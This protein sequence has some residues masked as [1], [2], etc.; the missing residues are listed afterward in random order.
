MCLIAWHWQPGA[1]EPLVLLSNRDEFFNRPA[2]TL[3][4][5]FDAPIWAGRDELAGGTWLGVGVSG[6]MA[7]ITN[8]RS[9]HSS[10]EL[11]K[12]RGH[13][14]RD[15]LLSHLSALDYAAYVAQN[16]SAYNPFN[17]WLFDGQSM[18]GVQ[19]RHSQSK[20]VTLTPGYGSVSN[21]DFNSPWPK[22][23]QLQAQLRTLIESGHAADDTLLDLLR[24][25]QTTQ[26]G[27]L[28]QTGVA[29][30]KELALSAMFVRLSD[31]GTRASTLVRY[32][33]E[34]V[35]M[36]ERS[37]DAQG[38]LNACVAEARVPRAPHAHQ[39]HRI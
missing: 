36:K 26:L 15:F 17:L 38:Q 27:D 25:T 5:W 1:P 39:V 19:G 35:R 23:L 18:M 32:G 20:V 9:M 8:Y 11:A 24:N 37:F 21:A 6:R 34:I 2:R 14:V 22:Q 30:E 4:R 33:L 31:Y 12:S 7:A 13:M 29:P 16:A 10:N 28:P 3:Q